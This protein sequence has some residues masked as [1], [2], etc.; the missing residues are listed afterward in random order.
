VIIIFEREYMNNAIIGFILLG[1]SSFTFL[2]GIIWT[3]GWINNLALFVMKIYKDEK[4]ELA[5]SCN[6]PAIY[7]S[8]TF[9]LFQLSKVFLQF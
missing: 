6:F 8:L 3:I 4:A 1:L 5:V 7:F 9:L 2:F